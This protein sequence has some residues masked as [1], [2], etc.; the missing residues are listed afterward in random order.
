MDQ[1]AIVNAMKGIIKTN[2]RMQCKEFVIL[3]NY[4]YQLPLVP[5]LGEVPQV[6]ILGT[7]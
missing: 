1:M 7:T 2:G 4:F 6:P 5:N 3:V